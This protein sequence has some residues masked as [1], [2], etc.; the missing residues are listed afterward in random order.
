MIY[1]RKNLNLKIK[2]KNKKQWNKNKKYT[3]ILLK[4]IHHLII[5]LV[6]PLEYISLSLASG[7]I[8]IFS[9]YF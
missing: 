3:Y 8:K 7:K 6:I 2:I 1:L 9:K 4:V 5:F